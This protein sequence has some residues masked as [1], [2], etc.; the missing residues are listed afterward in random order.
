MMV[1]TAKV[2][3]PEEAAFIA[4][5]LQIHAHVQTKKAANARRKGLGTM[6]RRIEAE[7]AECIRLANELNPDSEQT[8]SS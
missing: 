8:C 6:A 1:P 2:L 3:T 5:R 4:R 7:I